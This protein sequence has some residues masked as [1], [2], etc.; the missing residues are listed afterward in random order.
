M[1]RDS[2]LER[3]GFFCGTLDEPSS[4]RKAAF[5]ISEVVFLNLKLSLGIRA[6]RVDLFL[7]LEGPGDSLV[8]MK[9]GLVQ[10]ENITLLG[11]GVRVRGMFILKKSSFASSWIFF[12]VSMLRFC[13]V[14]CC[15]L[16]SSSV[17]SDDAA[18]YIQQT[19]LKLEKEQ[20]YI[21]NWKVIE[22]YVSTH[23]VQ[24]HVLITQLI[25]GP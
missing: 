9:T 8:S 4:A 24:E 25:L 11:D 10:G 14:L 2:V 3:K 22:L 18:P 12:G 21:K 20:I 13:F 17:I 6:L 7:E 1:I 5:S 19:F 23:I 15:P 16:G